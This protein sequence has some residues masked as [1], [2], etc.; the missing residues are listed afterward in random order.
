MGPGH[1]I[2]QYLLSRCKSEMSGGKKRLL[3]WQVP[4]AF[5]FFFLNM[6]DRW[7][8]SKVPLAITCLS[9][10]AI[11]LLAIA[12]SIKVFMIVFIKLVKVTLAS[13]NGFAKRCPCS[14]QSQEV[15]KGCRGGV[16]SYRPRSLERIDQEKTR[17]NPQPSIPPPERLIWIL[18]AFWFEGKTSV[19]KHNEARV[20]FR[21]SFFYGF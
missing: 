2:L 9:L 10:L 6:K 15:W 20:I 5:W 11:S 21:C 19:K 1:N 4:L 17:C 3:V 18:L 14:T 7:L 8:L 12:V 16:G 13:L